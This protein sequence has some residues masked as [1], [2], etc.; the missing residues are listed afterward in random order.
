MSPHD[1]KAVLEAG[2]LSFPL[3]D[4]DAQLDFDPAGYAARLEWLQPYGASALFAAGAACLVAA[5]LVM[6][7]RAPSAAAG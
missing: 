5:V 3:T 4:F 2:L 6:R 1:L 7:L